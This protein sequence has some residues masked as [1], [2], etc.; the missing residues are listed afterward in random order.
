MTIDSWEGTE[1][2]IPWGPKCKKKK[3]SPKRQNRTLGECA[4]ARLVG[5]GPSSF[6]S[7]VF[8]CFS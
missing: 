5:V 8:P 6:S 7:M 3:S 4:C 2:L 1:G